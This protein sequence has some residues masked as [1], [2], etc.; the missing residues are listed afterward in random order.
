MG[1][2]S[3]PFGRRT[4]GVLAIHAAALN[5]ES[6]WSDAQLDVLVGWGDI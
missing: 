4:G 2:V 3:G 6:A 1:D 5:F